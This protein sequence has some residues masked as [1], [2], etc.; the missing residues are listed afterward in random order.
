M[1]RKITISIPT[2]DEDVRIEITP[3]GKDTVVITSDVPKFAVNSFELVSA[4]FEA[5]KY[6]VE[7]EGKEQEETPISSSAT[8][9]E[10]E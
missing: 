4:V 2:S 8:K 9:Y 10:Y 7:F 1:R 3:S 6:R 5:E